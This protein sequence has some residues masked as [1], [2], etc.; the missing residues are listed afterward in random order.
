MS[1][2]APSPGWSVTEIAALRQSFGN[3]ARDYHRLR[4]GYPPAAFDF[5]A[6]L[7]HTAAGTDRTP[8][9]LDLGAGTGMLAAGLLSRG[10]DV[11]GVEP[12]DRMRT[13]LAEVLGDRNALAGTAEAIP[14]PDNSVDLVTAGQMW[15]WVNQR[16]AAAEVARVLRPGGVLAICWTLR[17]DRVGWVA[18]F[19]ATVG[20]TDMYLSAATDRPVELPPPFAS[21]HLTEF[22]FG[23]RMNAADLVDQ[24]ATFATVAMRDGP[25]RLAVAGDFLAANPATQGEFIAPF[26]CKIFIASLP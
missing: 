25:N 4:P 21:A 5:L 2:Q 15:H 13:V 7:A 11:V 3:W 10:L 14:V 19:A 20:L 9:C 26:V 17:D 12:D 16:H 23:L 8:D 24:L 22:E 6:G 18:D 1:E